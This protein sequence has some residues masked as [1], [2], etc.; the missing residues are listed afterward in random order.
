[1]TPRKLGRILM[2][3]IGVQAICTLVIFSMYEIASKAT[4]A[5]YKH[6]KIPLRGVSVSGL[7]TFLGRHASRMDFRSDPVMEGIYTQIK[8]LLS[9]QLVSVGE[10][11]QSWTGRFVRTSVHRSTLFDQ[12]VYNV[13]YEQSD[14]IRDRVLV[15]NVGAGLCTRYWRLKL[16]EQV[17]V[18]W[19]DVDGTESI[20]WKR[21][22]LT[23]IETVDLNGSHYSLV[24]DDDVASGRAA[25]WVDAVRARTSSQAYDRIVIIAEGVFMYSPWEKFTDTMHGIASQ[26]NAPAPLVIMD[27]NHPLSIWA[28]KLFRLIMYPIIKLKVH[29]VLSWPG[30]VVFLDNQAYWGAELSDWEGLSFVES[31]VSTKKVM[32]DK[33]TD[34]SNDGFISIGSIAPGILVWWMKVVGGGP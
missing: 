28:W 24:I 8:P 7:Y 21:S 33:N 26:W 20:N 30:I 25:P 1:M 29:H 2:Y 13:L 14:A 31:I 6:E 17:N 23:G 32:Q 9:S 27:V 5:S 22:L 3:V 18:D 12:I 34:P 15:V 19:I 11:R 16:P 4:P 10:D